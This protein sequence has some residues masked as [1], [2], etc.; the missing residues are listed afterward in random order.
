M[1]KFEDALSFLVGKMR[2]RNCVTDKKCLDKLPIPLWFRE[3]LYFPLQPR[4][5]CISTLN[6]QVALRLL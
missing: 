5:M 6:A 1:R 4:F 3:G 2:A